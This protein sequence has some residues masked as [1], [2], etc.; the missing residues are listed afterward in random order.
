M[1]WLSFLYNKTDI[2]N[3]KSLIYLMFNTVLNKNI[4]NK[5]GED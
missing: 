5:I 3:T 4:Y 1:I 2:F